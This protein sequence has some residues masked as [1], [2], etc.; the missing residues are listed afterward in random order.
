[1]ANK[2]IINLNLK[3]F[4]KLLFARSKFVVQ[5]GDSKFLARPRTFDLYTINEVFKTKFYLPTLIKNTE[6]KTIIDIGANIGAFTVWANRLF[7]PEI[8]VCLEPEIE[9]F[10][11]LRQN[12]KLN[13]LPTKTR[14]LNLAAYDEETEIGMFKYPVITLMHKIDKESGKNIVKTVTLEKLLEN[15]RINYADYLKIDIE[16]AEQFLLTPKNEKIFKNRVGYINMELH[17]LMGY[18]RF[19]GIDYF[20][21]LGF[22]TKYSEPTILPRVGRL[23]ALNPGSPS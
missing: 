21:K 9:N 2:K 16:G 5:A 14:L 19:K 3:Y 8:I 11:L 12:V 17:S 22:K 4:L 7:N 1:M 15:L 23:E 18:D 10:N 20:E 6:I 13:N